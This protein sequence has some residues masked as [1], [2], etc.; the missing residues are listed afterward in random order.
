M[1]RV[2]LEGFANI[3][4]QPQERFYNLLCLAVGADPVQFADLAEVGYLPPTRSA[5]CNYEYRKVVDAFRKEISPHI[6]RE[7]AMRVLIQ[8]GFPGQN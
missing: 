7:M 8:T 4:G 1:I 5:T 6:D 3:H 2:R